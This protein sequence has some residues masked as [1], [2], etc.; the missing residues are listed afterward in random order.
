[1]TEFKQFQKDV[2]LSSRKDMINFLSNHMKYY[3]ANSWNQIESYA[4]NIKIHNL[5]VD[6]K[7][8][9]MFYDMLDTDATDMAYDVLTDFRTRYDGRYQIAS[10]GRSGG[11]LVLY[12]GY[13]KESQYKSR[14]TK[15]GQFNF[16]FATENDCRCGRCCENTRVNFSHP[17]YEYGVTFQPLDDGDFDE[18]TDDELKEQ[19]LLVQDF[20]ATCDAYIQALSEIAKDYTVEEEIVY[21]PETRR[22]LRKTED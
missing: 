8:K 17:L 15:C 2:D 11:Y 19:V 7:T 9:D 12:K 22:V 16:Q 14:C 18:W 13:K 3:L 20:D 21:V 6:S 4:N 5:N 10:N 1:M